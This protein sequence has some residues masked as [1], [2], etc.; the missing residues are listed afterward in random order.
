MQ[1]S[2]HAEARK[3][4]KEIDSNPQNYLIIH[5]SCESFYDIKDGHTPR[6]TS[7][8]VYNYATAQT[9]SF[10]IH[11]VAERKHITMDEIECH[12]DELEKEMLDEFFA[13]AK[14]HQTYSWI[15]WNMRDMNYGFR[16][17]E[18]RYSVLGGEPYR[19]SD[20]QKI[21]LSRQLI[22]CY[23]ANYIEHPRMQKLLE[24]NSIEA[25]DYLNGKQEAEAFEN[26]EYVKLHMSTLRKVD[27][28][29]DILTL[30]INN[31]LKVNAKWTEIYGIS[32]QGI[33]NLCKDTWWIQIVWTI[34]SMIL[35]ALVSVGVEN[36]L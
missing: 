25:K 8:A 31:T 18:H 19:I 26:H 32:I 23:G 27:V 36:L 7:I 1:Y 13:Y 15:H 9:D 17:I 33:F 5:Y 12:Y 3:I 24:L 21:D 28:F 34:I 22:N 10:S 29:A 6:I 2:R 35:G 30:A 16:A 20:S 4:F 11:K 14:E